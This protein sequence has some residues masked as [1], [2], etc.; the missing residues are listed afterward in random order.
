MLIEDIEG[1]EELNESSDS[2]GL[3]E[4]A[5]RVLDTYMMRLYKV[6]ANQF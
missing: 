1:E 4:E 5:S 3:R 6:G 2:T